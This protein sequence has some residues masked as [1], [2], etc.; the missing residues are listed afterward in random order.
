MLIKSI[1]TLTQG[2]L[3]S[4][5]LGRDKDKMIEY[6]RNKTIGY[7]SNGELQKAFSIP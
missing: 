2:I 3:N 1:Q 4:G 7:D 5:L 6:F